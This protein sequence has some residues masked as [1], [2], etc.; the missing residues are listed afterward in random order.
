VFNLNGQAVQKNIHS[1]TKSII[2]TKGK[3]MIAE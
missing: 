3:K 1:G 2:I